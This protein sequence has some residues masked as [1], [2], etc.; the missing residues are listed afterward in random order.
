[1]SDDN[2]EAFN[3]KEA[4]ERI[5]RRINDTNRLLNNAPVQ[6]EMAVRMKI[7]GPFIADL[8]W[9]LFDQT[10]EANHDETRPDLTLAIDQTTKIV[11]ETK[12][13]NVDLNSDSANKQLVSYAVNI[14]AEIVAVTNG[15]IWKLFLSSEPVEWKRK[16]FL[17]IDIKNDNVKNSAEMFVK[18]LHKESVRSS[19]S[20]QFAKGLIK[21]RSTTNIN[22]LIDNLKPDQQNLVRDFIVNMT[23]GQELV[24]DWK[25]D[26]PPEIPQPQTP[27][28]ASNVSIHNVHR[29][30]QVNIVALSRGKQTVLCSNLK[31]GTYYVLLP[32]KAGPQNGKLRF[33]LSPE[34]ERFER[35]IHS[36]YGGSLDRYPLKYIAESYSSY[37]LR[38]NT[39]NFW[40]AMK[41]EGLFTLWDPE[42]GPKKYF[43][44]TQGKI[45]ILRVYEIDR[46]LKE[47]VHLIGNFHKPVFKGPPQTV[48]AK[49]LKTDDQ[50]VAEDKKLKDILQRFGNL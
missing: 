7:I 20:L 27:G 40:V 1:M 45:Q 2:K 13:T 14:G 32:T 31:S 28:I 5:V 39:L 50:M 29:N 11:I 17:D 18:L 33:E 12:A 19:T 23:S 42:N 21:I 48:H 22:K 38:K 4:Y 25:H 43:D 46:D 44:K 47:S 41:N 15:V 35:Q 3:F 6:N 26:I 8:G 30:E 24:I 9:E 34:G 37:N 10:W 49:P 16:N 36:E